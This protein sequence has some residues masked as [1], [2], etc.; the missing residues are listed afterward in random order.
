MD[1]GFLLETNFANGIYTRVSSVYSFLET[2]APSHHWEGVAVFYWYSPFFILKSHQ[3]NGPNFSSLHLA[4][5][6]QQWFVM[7]GYLS[8]DYSSII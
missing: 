7:G 8:P 3:K 1:L 6:N 2:D 4:L 5:S